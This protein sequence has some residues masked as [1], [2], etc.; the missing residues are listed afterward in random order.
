MTV[1]HPDTDES[2]KPGTSRR[3]VLRSGAILAGTGVVGLPLFTGS[4]VAHGCAYTPGYWKNHP[5]AWMPQ[6]D[7]G[8]E[9]HIH[10]DSSMLES[11]EG[12]QKHYYFS[13]PDYLGNPPSCM[14]VLWMSPKGDKSI[15]MAHHFI[16]AILNGR[17]DTQDWCIQGWDSADR[18]YHNPEKDYI[19]LAREFFD[20]HPVGSG[21][22]KWDGYEYVK[23]KL[24]AYNE[25]R[26]CV[27]GD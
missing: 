9:P 8:N 14:D 25:G 12:N 22:R 20:K 6:T 7:D 5:E 3:S 2:T 16:A 15:I 21:A 24:E 23:D 17:N 4:A 1:D 19:H 10:F 13:S 26:L 27:C 11:G 18:M